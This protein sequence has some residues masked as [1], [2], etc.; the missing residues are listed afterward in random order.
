MSQI[1]RLSALGIDT[2]RLSD[3][4]RGVLTALSAEELAVLANVKER[5]ET[6]DG[7]VQGHSD[8]DVI[9]GVIF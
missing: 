3:E 9:G 4:Q 2:E 7:D 1:A 8:S 6:A 5:L